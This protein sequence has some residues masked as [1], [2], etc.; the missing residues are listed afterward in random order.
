MFD[1]RRLNKP[2]EFYF[3]KKRQVRV[4]CN[5]LRNDSGNA[6]NSYGCDANGRHVSYSFFS[7]SFAISRTVTAALISMPEIWT[8]YSQSTIARMFKMASE[9][10]AFRL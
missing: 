2:L 7:T 3:V 8:E 6:S 1:S 9:S 10:H 4:I 5:S